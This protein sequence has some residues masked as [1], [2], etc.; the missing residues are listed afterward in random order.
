MP[1]LDRHILFCLETGIYINWERQVNIFAIA[2]S[3]VRKLFSFSNFQF[4]YKFLNHQV[5]DILKKLASGAKPKSPPQKL[6]IEHISGPLFIILFGYLMACII[7]MFEVFGH[8]LKRT[9][10]NGG[11]YLTKMV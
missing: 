10:L 1:L 3:L 4:S 8:R 9:I 11:R 6:S 5:Q 7:L 2:V